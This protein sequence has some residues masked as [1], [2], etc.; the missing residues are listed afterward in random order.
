MYKLAPF[1]KV[2]F[3]SLLICFL[4]GCAQQ[5]SAKNSKSFSMNITSE[6]STLDPA[7]SYD[8]V[9]GTI[10]Y[11]VYEQLYEYHYLNR[12][13]ELKPLLAEEMPKI[14]DG[15]KR[16]IIRIKKNIRYHDD[17][18]FKGKTRF[19]KA[20]DF[21]TSIK[22]LVFKPLN[23]TGSWLVEDL[24]VGIEDFTKIVGDDFKKLQTT[25][26]KGVYSRDEYTLVIELSRPSPQ[27]I[28]KLAMS[29]V[30]PTPMEVV[31]HYKNDLTKHA[32][33]TGA[34]Y[35]KSV[36]PAKEIQLERFKNYHETFYPGEGDRYA[37]SIGLL[38][39]A[40]EKLPLLE[41]V[42]I[43]VLKD[44][45]DRWQKFL[46]KEIDVLVIPQ[47][48]HPEVFDE[49]G[50]LNEKMKKMNVHIQT[51]PTLTFWWLAFNMKDPTLGKSA[52]LRR[53]IAHAID[54]D[55]YVKRFTNN[56]GQKANSI[57]SPGVFGYSPS[58]ELS[59]KYDLNL[60]KDYL[61]KAGYPEGKGLPEIVY[62]TRAESKLSNAQAEYFKSQLAKVGI[63]LKIVKNNFNEYLEK[64]RTG[65]LQFFQDGWTLDYPDAEN[66]FQ[67][68]H[69][70]NHPPGPNASLYS[71]AKF[72]E[73]YSRISKLPDGDERMQLMGEA[74]A[75][76]NHDVPWIMQY[77]SRNFIL[78]H[79]YVKNYRPSDIVFN[80]LKYIRVK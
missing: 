64:S 20:E 67:L 50:N 31:E 45:K 54:M 42:N 33:G 24:V 40:G 76:I 75:I 34:F 27:F 13:Y 47:D 73:L 30:S 14:E 53:A 22:R 60:S 66:I 37:N 44:N 12:P 58:Q 28:Y 41:S 51:M 72:D 71:N 48:L 38:K 32:V 3:F 9:S 26:I 15:G 23:S 69:T 19:V 46:N 80:Y 21:I 7:N 55:E 39:D 2:S 25:P 5:D 6:L 61:V 43:K 4:A 35:I 16:Y 57:L 36:D 1:L 62:D 74:Q 68:L 49:Y 79:D 17:P 10:M 52:D 18:A 63:R 77:Y 8:N 56:T 59:Y 29:F 65:H 70:S 78:Y 11:Q